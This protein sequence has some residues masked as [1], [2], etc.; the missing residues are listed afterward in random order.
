MVVVLVFV[1]V[2]VVVLGG[3]GGNICGGIGGS[4]GFIVVLLRMSVNSMHV[5]GYLPFYCLGYSDSGVIAMDK[6]LNCACAWLTS[7]RKIDLQLEEVCMNWI[8]RR[9]VTK[10][11][12]S[13]NWMLRAFQISYL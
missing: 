2:V 4:K 13:L 12:V 11:E 3:S 8:G 1:V 5:Y 10:L 9:S 6:S 7:L